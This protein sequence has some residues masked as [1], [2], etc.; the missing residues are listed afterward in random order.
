[1]ENQIAVG[2]FVFS[3]TDLSETRQKCLFLCFS[4]FLC[5]MNPCLKGTRWVTGIS[6]AGGQPKSLGPVNIV[7]FPG[8]HNENGGKE[9]VIKVFEMFNRT[10]VKLLE[11]TIKWVE[12]KIIGAGGQELHQW[13]NIPFICQGTS[14]PHTELR[15]KKPDV[16]QTL[17]TLWPWTSQ[18][19]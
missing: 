12:P 11:G 2:T 8:L 10:Y 19:F 18:L 3:L 13:V 14:Q 9:S 6:G 5:P 16:R 17:I 4:E 7:P 15:C 1:M